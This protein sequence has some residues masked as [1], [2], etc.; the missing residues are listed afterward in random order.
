MIGLRHA[1]RH[2][3][4]DWRSGELAVVALALVIAVTG[5]TSI[6]FVGDRLRAAMNEQAARF[7]GADLRL[8]GPNPI[9]PSWLAEARQRGL[10]TSSAVEFATMA[11][12]GEQMQLVSAKAVDPAYPL[13]GRLKT[14]GAP[15]GVEQTAERGPQ[16]GEVWLESRLFGLLGTQLGATI[17]IGEAKFR[18]AAVLAHDPGEAGDMFNVAPHLLMHS[19]DLPATRIIQPGSR[20]GHQALF[21]GEPKAREA[22]AA[23][24]Q[25]RLS[26]SQRLRGGREGSEALGSAFERAESY[27]SLAG[28][29]SVVLAGIAI[30]MAAQRYAERHFDMSAILRCFGARKRD[31]LWLF[32]LALLLLG[33]AASL[34]GSVF[35]YLAHLGLSELLRER[36]PDNLPAPGLKPVGVGLV[37]GVALLVGFAL[38]ALLRLQRVP[39]LRVLKRDLDPL[40]A[41]TWLV[42]GLAFA[43]LAALMAW[44]S[45]SWQLTGIVLAGGAAG[46]AV[47]SLLAWGILKLTGRAAKRLPAAQRFGV[48]HLERHR[49]ESLT[50]ILAF[51]MTL[52]V[53]LAILLVRTDLLTSWQNQLPEDASNHFL[54]NI[55]PD[56]VAAVKAFFLA[57]DI[58]SENLYPMVRGRMLA[59]NEI[60]IAEAVPEMARGDNAL[61]RE[62]NLSWGLAKPSDNE[63]IEGRWWTPEDQGKLL[64]S[65]ESLLA[66]RFGFVLGDRL[67]FQVGG[68]TVEATIASLRKVQWD[69]FHPNFYVMFPPGAIEQF[70]S[71]WITSFYLPKARKPVLNELVRRFPTQT[72]IE[73]DQLMAEVKAVLTQ[74]TLAVEYLLVFVLL[75]GFA[76]LA[77]C[78]QATLDERLFEAVV[79]RT[80]GASRAFLRRALSTEFLVLGLLA[81]LL[82]ALAAEAIAYGLYTRAFN[83]DPVVHPWL[84]LAGP[85]AGMAA[86]GLGGALSSRR[87]ANEPPLKSLRAI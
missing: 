75:A 76:V 51:G 7:L 13:R 44:H 49:R 38:P 23:W 45:G 32:A 28:L 35:G 10:R 66:Q 82:A 57:R 68:E 46:T 31:V 34:V 1:L 16:P 43:T 22:Y 39:V 9:D 56:E 84:W 2:L 8:S 53:M 37:S 29:I 20:V 47:L 63:I 4:R 11:V 65:V 64:I 26:A 74:I 14:A 58:R 5:I 55:Q 6:G 79:L 87:V 48:S 54:V 27:L 52:T 80:L 41:A 73:V 30:A 77:A 81:G 62:L 70:P 24:L 61:R 21:A 50:Q 33:V 40:P 12:A 85:L 60:P 19:A 72:V 3:A 18:V 78:L 71:A 17:E 25:P 36:L 67:S 86:I 59:K 83:L 42:Y 15:Y 69:S